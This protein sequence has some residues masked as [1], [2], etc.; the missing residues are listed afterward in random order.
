MGRL[1]LLEACLHVAYEW[2]G[3]DCR[4]V[5]RLLDANY[6][7]GPVLPRDSASIH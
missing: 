4:H 2:P 7:E 5:S 1:S 6:L 3:V